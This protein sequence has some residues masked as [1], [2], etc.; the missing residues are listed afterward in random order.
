MRLGENV[1][2]PRI[3]SSYE[4]LSARMLDKHGSKYDYSESVFTHSK[5]KMKFICKDHGEFYQTPLQHIRAKTPCMQ[6][7]RIE[8]GKGKII[9]FKIFEEKAIKK[10]NG[11]YIY[12]EANYIDMSTPMEMICPEHGSFFKKPTDHISSRRGNNCPGCFVHPGQSNTEEFIEKA[13][14]IHGEAFDYSKVVYEKAREKVQIKCNTCGHTFFQ[15]PNNHLVGKGCRKCADLAMRNTQEEFIEKAKIVHG[16]KYILDSAIYTKYT[17]PII[18]TCKIHGEFNTTPNTFLGGSG[19]PEC[20]NALSPLTRHEHTPTKFYVIKYKGLYK[21][22]IT[23]ENAIQRYRWEVDNIDEIEVL[24]EIVFEGYLKAYTFEQFLLNKYY[25]LRYRGAKIFKH[26]GITEV[27][28]EDIYQM[29][30]QKA[31]NE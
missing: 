29:Y 30:L 22:G 24:T 4:G 5:D 18:I 21:V 14:I 7:S 26:T 13:K 2:N 27:F 15:K 1:T 17:E 25:R 20:S 19:C 10:Y 8:T 28:T 23:L 31:N 11:K 6:C 16:G 3:I 9:P 12:L